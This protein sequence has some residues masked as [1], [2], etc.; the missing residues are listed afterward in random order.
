M[1]E[2][3]AGLGAQASDGNVVFLESG[4]WTTTLDINKS[5]PCEGLTPMSP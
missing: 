2:K 3:T 4:T 1:E 5:W